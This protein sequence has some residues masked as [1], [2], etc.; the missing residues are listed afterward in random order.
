MCDRSGGQTTSELNTCSVHVVYVSDFVLCVMC[1]YRL[2]LVYF[3]LL[4]M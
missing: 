2:I 1:V 3:V 4:V